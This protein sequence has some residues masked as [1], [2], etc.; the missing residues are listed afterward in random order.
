MAHRGRDA[1]DVI[2]CLHGGRH[3]M[4]QAQKRRFGCPEPC[5][6]S[7]SWLGKKEA[8]HLQP[9]HESIEP[10]IAGAVRTPEAETKARIPETYIWLLVPGQPN[11][12]AGLAWSEIKLQGNEPLAVRASKRLRNEDLLVTVYAGTLLRMELDR[13]PL[14]RGDHVLLKQLAE[15]FAQYLYLPR[16]KDSEVLVG[17]VNN[18]LGMFSWELDSFAY[19]QGYDEATGR[20]RGLIG[21]SLASSMSATTAERSRSTTT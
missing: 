8:V 18:G 14:W 19:A 4:R 10:A 1:I 7:H 12:T 6:N 2:S 17:A 16:P 13:I 21:G 5:R 11:K 15:D 9:V 3:A 20:Y